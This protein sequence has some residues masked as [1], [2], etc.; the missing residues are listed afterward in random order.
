MASYVTSML[1]GHDIAHMVLTNNIFLPDIK[2]S[3]ASNMVACVLERLE[4]VKH[5]VLL[6]GGP[7]SDES[8]R[9][10]LRTQRFIKACQNKCVPEPGARQCFKDLCLMWRQC[11]G[12]QARG[13]LAADEI[14]T[15]AVDMVVREGYLT[16][17]FGD[18]A[19][20]F[21]SAGDNVDPSQHHRFLKDPGLARAFGH[22]DA[23]NSRWSSCAACSAPTST[24][25][26]PTAAVDAAV[27]AVQ[28]QAE[29]DKRAAVDAVVKAVQQQA[30]ADK[31]AAVDAAVKAV[32]QQAEADKRAAV[33]AAVKAVQHHGD[34]DSYRLGTGRE[35]GCPLVRAIGSHPRVCKCT[36]PSDFSQAK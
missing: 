1:T 8:G 25:S 2:P 9:R 26:A 21:V 15:S 12:R 34:I 6:K 20:E 18:G 16:I 22:D 23:L 28:Q 14:P 33:D 17:R 10:V 30:E 3:T 35:S 27:K 32:Q 19:F 36:D 7:N 31:R 11:H 24:T 29:A 13:V 4:F 5:I